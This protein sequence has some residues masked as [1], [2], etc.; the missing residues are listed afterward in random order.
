VILIYRGSKNMVT[1]GQ[2]R[3]D[4]AQDAFDRENGLPGIPPV[5]HTPTPILKAHANTQEEQVAKNIWLLMHGKPLP[6]RTKHQKRI[7]AQH[8]ANALRS[9]FSSAEMA[10]RLRRLGY[11]E[12]WCHGRLF[13]VSLDGWADVRIGHEG[14]LRTGRGVKVLDAFPELG[15]LAVKAGQQTC[16]SGAGAATINIT[17][18]GSEQTDGAVE[19]W[20][21]SELSGSL[22]ITYAKAWYNVDLTGGSSNT[23]YATPDAGGSA[24]GSIVSPVAIPGSCFEEWIMPLD[25]SGNPIIPMGAIVSSAL[26][27]YEIDHTGAGGYYFEISDQYG[28]TS[29]N[30]Q[31][32]GTEQASFTWDS[33]GIARLQGDVSQG[34]SFPT[35]PL[36]SGGTSTYSVM[37]GSAGTAN[38]HQVQLAII[39]TGSEWTLNNFTDPFSV[40]GF[41]TQGSQIITTWSGDGLTWVANNAGNS[42][43]IPSGG[44][45]SDLFQ[46]WATIPSGESVEIS[47]WILVL[48]YVGC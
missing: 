44:S 33:A 39:Y 16:Y 21:L 48:T 26:A 9:C 11:D 27:E 34:T 43:A 4:R 35:F 1:V 17:G 30:V 42:N 20:D 2:E 14:Q 31:D 45:V 13:A 18:D 15:V 7:A 32:T 24:S 23:A 6:G 8:L 40:G 28:S 38:G 41:A 5:F 47:Q 46:A 19:S 29:G 37:A 12:H 36:F 25:H 3:I 10:V 22:T